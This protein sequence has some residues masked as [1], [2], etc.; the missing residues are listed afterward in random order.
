MNVLSLEHVTKRFRR[1]ERPAV[2]DV[3]FAV[4]QAHFTALVGESG[5]GKT[6]LLRIIAGLEVPDEGRVLIREQPVFD[7]RV[8]QP[9]EKRGVGLVFQNHALFPHLDVAGN[10]G[11]GLARQT[12][13]Q[14]KRAIDR[15]LELVG[16]EGYDKRFPHELSG[17]ERQR[18]ALARALAPQPAII[19]LDEPFSNLDASLRHRVR[20]EVRSI[21]REVG[22]T[23][24][25]VTHDTKDALSVADQVVVLREGVVQQVGAPQEI[26]HAPGNRYVAAFFGACN[27]LPLSAFGSLHQA[28][29]RCLI[30]PRNGIGIASPVGLWIRPEDIEMV[31]PAQALAHGGL[32]GEVKQVTFCGEYRE[33]LVRGRLR[34]GVHT[35]IIVYRDHGGA[36]TPGETVGLLPRLRPVKVRPVN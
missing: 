3:S 31:P 30:G 29:A 27:F 8:N 16:L 7:G 5:S 9:P 36:V 25:F 2:A 32:E 26:Y 22:A 35:D 4:E 14:R 18:V 23:A 19:L 12:R 6:T 24:L 1:D 33:V 28:R 20:D 11:F 10:I 17:G 21:L 13:R 34:N 15:M